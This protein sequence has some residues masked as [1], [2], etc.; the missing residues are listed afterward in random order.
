[1]VYEYVD[2]LDNL[3]QPINMKLEKLIEKKNHDSLSNHDSPLQFQN[4]KKGYSFYNS[5]Y[6]KH[7]N[8]ALLYRLPSLTER[9][10]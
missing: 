6:P 10:I 7:H 2:E 3:T 4:Y 1:M 9:L 5:L 8:L